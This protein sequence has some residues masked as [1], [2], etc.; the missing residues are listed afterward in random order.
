ML[1]ILAIAAVVVLALLGILAIIGGS[2]FRAL[3]SGGG[4]SEELPLADEAPLDYAYLD[5]ERAESYLGQALNGLPTSEQDTKALTRAVDVSLGAA[6]SAQLSGSQQL[7]QSTVTTV[8]PQ[9]VDRFYTFLRLLR[10]GHEADASRP[11]TCRSERLEHK[12]RPYWLGEINDQASKEVIISEVKCIGVGNFVRI[13]NA[14]LFLPPFA[15]ALPRLQS[16]NAFVG[17]LPTP[18]TPFTSPVQSAGLRHALDQYA[19]RVGSNPRIPVVAA[20]FGS[21]E[22]VGSGVTVFLP[23]RYRGITSEPSLLSG[24]VTI[25]GKIVYFGEERR[26]AS[27]TR[28]RPEPA[29]VD[30]P[31]VFTFGQALRGAE[32]A[33]QRDLGVC[34]STPPHSTRRRRQ[35]ARAS[36]ATTSKH[37]LSPRPAR[38][39]QHAARRRARCI[40]AQ[41]ALSDVRAS[42]SFAPPVIVVLP[43]AI[44]Q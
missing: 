25:V 15:Q 38:H 21:P 8:T 16:A 18:R 41:A 31:T 23:T 12:E 30:Y 9:A 3:D 27:P 14:Q 17:A 11:D 22:L 24:S 19:R 34:S 33:L 6:A 36:T 1:K 43:L 29:Y 10:K 2:P 4:V 20:P 37:A 40:S 5:T 35:E 32:P 26:A 39:N 13:H 28:T 44:Y 42:I 7:Q